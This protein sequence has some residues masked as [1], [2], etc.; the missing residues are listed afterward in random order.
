MVRNSRSHTEC[1]MISRYW[2][3]NYLVGHRHDIIWGTIPKLTCRDWEYPRKTV[4]FLKFLDVGWEW[5]HMICRPLIDLLYQTRMVDDGCGAVY[6]MRIG[7]GN[8][9]NQ[10]KTC[11]S[12]TLSTTNL[13]WP[14]PGLN[15]NRLSY[16]T[17]YGCIVSIV[18]DRQSFKPHAS[19]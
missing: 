14:D 17:V 13:I 11:P 19:Q 18:F 10:E 2:F 6:G 4:H 3:R 7:S 1:R 9:S 15:T 8:Q 5:V 12:A 16:G